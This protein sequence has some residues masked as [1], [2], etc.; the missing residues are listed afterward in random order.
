MGLRS[1]DDREG[2]FFIPLF[3]RGT[4]AASLRIF[5]MGP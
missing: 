5:R 4:L 1:G 2:Q 3:L